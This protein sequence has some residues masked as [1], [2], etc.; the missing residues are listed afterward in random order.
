MEGGGL[1]PA[2]MARVTGHGDASP[3]VEDPLALRNERLR[4]TILRD[5]D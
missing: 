5:L 3:A 4:I 1:D 2:R